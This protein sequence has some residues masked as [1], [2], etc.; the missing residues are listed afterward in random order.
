MS[1]KPKPK[2]AA[3]AEAE[4]NEAADRFVE[5]YRTEALRFK[6]WAVVFLGSVQHLPANKVNAMLNAAGER[7]QAAGAELEKDIKRGEA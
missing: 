5:A 6:H 3:Q 7:M 1:R 4:I 2:T